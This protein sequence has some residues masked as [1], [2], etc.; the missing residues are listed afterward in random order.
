MIASERFQYTSLT[1]SSWDTS[2]VTDMH[3]MFYGCSS[4]VSFDL[5]SWDVSS[6]TDMHQMFADCSKLISL[7]LSNWDVSSVTEMRQMF[8]GNVSLKLLDLSGW[9]ASSI[10]DMSYMFSNLSS[11]ESLDLSGWDTSG[12]TNMS[13]MFYRCSGLASLDISGWNTSSVKNMS[14]MFYDCFPLVSLDLS[15]WNTANVTNMGFMFYNCASLES[16]NLSG[17]DMAGVTYMDNMFIGCKSVATLVL[18]EGAKLKDLPP[19]KV[20]G[21]SDWYSAS[22]GRWYA[23]AEIIE[24]KLGSADVYTKGIGISSALVSGVVGKTYNGKAQTQ[25]PTLKLDSKILSQGA[26]Y[27]LSYKNNVNAGTATVTATG[28]GKYA[29]TVSK[30]FKI[31]KVTKAGKVTVTKGLKKGTYTIKVK[32]TSSATK[33]YKSAS[34]SVTLKIKVK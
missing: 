11:V 32:V 13:Y 9:D 12:A 5:S 2:S 15:N 29:G 19:S 22:E 34:K 1:L 18:G 27:T 4:L 17:W 25:E 24:S 7:K 31:A 3:Q 33:N 30:S 20:N 14:Y 16:L 6:V 28:V 10:K 8:Y 23:T 26:D 21:R